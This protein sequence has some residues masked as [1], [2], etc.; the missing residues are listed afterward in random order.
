MDSTRN[1][2]VIGEKVSMPSIDAL[3][4]PRVTDRV[5]ELMTT[6]IGHVHGAAGIGKTTALAQL[7][8]AWPGRIAWVRLDHGDGDESRL[9]ALL[10]GALGFTSTTGPGLIDEVIAELESGDGEARTLLVL[11]DLHSIAGSDAEQA[12]HR[13]IRYR[14]PQVALLMGSRHDSSLEIRALVG[15]V[16]PMIIDFEDLRF[17]VWEVDDLM[18]SHHDLPIAPADLHLLCRYTDGWAAALRLFWVASRDADPAH[19]T[20]LISRMRTNPGMMHDY[21]MTEVLSILRPEARDFLV[22][23]AVFE[24]IT[25]QRADALLG[26]ADARSVLREIQAAGLFGESSDA[27]DTYRC[28]DLLRTHLLSQLAASV[29]DDEASELQLRAAGLAEVEECPAEAI[30]YYARAGDFD[31]VRR[32]LDTS[33]GVLS[34]TPGRWIEVLP[35]AMREQD[36]FVSLTS[37]RQ[38]VRHGDLDEARE[39]YRRAVRLLDSSDGSARVARAELRSLDAWLHREPLPAAGWI[40]DVAR[41]VRSGDRHTASDDGDPHEFHDACRDLLFGDLRSAAAGF[42][43]VEQTRSGLEG[44]VA[45]VA[46]LLVDLIRGGVEACSPVAVR[47][48]QQAAKRIDAR[49]AERVVGAIARGAVGA[50]IHDPLSDECRQANDHLG[51]GL[52]HLVDGVALLHEGR[53]GGPSFGIAREAFMSGGYEELGLLAGLFHAAVLGVAD[54]DPGAVM[55]D[56]RVRRPGG[57]TQLLLLVVNDESGGVVEHGALSP[58]DRV[59]RQADLEMLAD[60]VRGRPMAAEDGAAPAV[61]SDPAAMVRVLGSFSVTLAGRPVVSELTP[62]HQEVLAYLVVHVGEWVHRDRLMDVFWP[63]KDESRAGRSLQVAVSKVRVEIERAEIGALAR[64]GAR[65]SF[66]PAELTSVDL[67]QLRALLATPVEPIEARADAVEA[68]LGLFGEIVGD[69]GASTWAVGP[70]REVRLEVSRAAAQVATTLQTAGDLTRAAR[71]A[72]NGVEVDPGADELWQ[73]AISCSGAAR[74]RQL[75][76]DYD[77]VIGSHRP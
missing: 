74:A 16:E 64:D 72:G 27:A 36:P 13:L 28:H 1:Q 31:S 60:R 47:R 29:G 34:S 19:R 21:L 9:V 61:V 30:R 41:L 75:Q 8:D 65:Y 4:R 62:L 49:A 15:S 23:T 71:I 38:L 7:A 69:L 48:V 22:A 59:A 40:G 70:R 6:G 66:V 46:G 17:R 24:Q 3:D 5:T 25:P 12:I 76:Q 45:G 53:G 10:R 58:V 51:M 37:A 57:L 68:A 63:D 20:Q 55:I 39:R 43:F 32:I 11:D 73:L 18:R 42:R 54:G 35:V 77:R 33:G 52:V 67:L 14:P 50:S 56:A 2:V 26:S 44:V